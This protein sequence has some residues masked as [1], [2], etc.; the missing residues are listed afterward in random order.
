[1]LAGELERAGYKV[2]YQPP[3]E[4]RGGVENDVIVAVI[5]IV[6]NIGSA[7]AYDGIK[8][9]VRAFKERQPRVK[10]EIEGGDES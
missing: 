1:M 5:S 9:A 2:Q 3:Q 10:V 7:T 4:R 8:R 6:T